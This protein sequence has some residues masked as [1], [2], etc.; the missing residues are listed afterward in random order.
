MYGFLVH[1]S[2]I[3]H[4][5]LEPGLKLV[6][7]VFAVRAFLT[8]IVFLWWLKLS[9]CCNL[10]I[11]LHLKNWE[12]SK[13][14]LENVLWFCFLL[15][16][17][18]LGYQWIICSKGFVK[19]YFFLEK[20]HKTVLRYAVNMELNYS[21]I[22]IFQKW[23]WLTD[24][25]VDLLLALWTIDFKNCLSCDRWKLNCRPWPCVSM[26]I[27]FNLSFHCLWLPNEFSAKQ[28][29]FWGQV[30]HH[31]IYG[32][33]IFYIKYLCVLLFYVF[34]PMLWKMFSLLFQNIQLY[35]IILGWKNGMYLYYKPY[36]FF[37]II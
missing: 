18:F 35:L 3:L 34:I 26:G 23:L 27:A 7:C 25:F 16:S 6:S 2:V 5:R 10:H 24:Y 33:L 32:G 17:F 8:Q 19:I 31:T 22:F 14:I 30:D 9:L 20:I 13:N 29:A 1:V 15:F 12:Y 36:F 21:A 11:G 37:C 28:I 4:V